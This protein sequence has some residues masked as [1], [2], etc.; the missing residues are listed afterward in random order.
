MTP[1]RHILFDTVLGRCGLV[2]GPGGVIA[3]S[4]PEESD[5]QT[6]ARLL[7]GR[8]EAEEAPCAPPT[9]ARIIDD[10][11]ALFEGAPR[12]LAYAGID[13]GAAPAFDRAVYD[14]TLAIK[15]GETRRYGDLARDLGDVGLSRR[16]GQALG[17][18]PVPI[19]VPCHRVVGANGLMTGFS[20]PGG[21]GT[22]RRLLRIEGALA[23]DL[24]DGLDG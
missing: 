14:L 8:G 15:P 5:A 17:R 21:T 20:A 1:I 16:V 18:N 23:P 22:K 6:R 10:I 19:I 3:A 2:W 12:D 9:I 24:F 11:R 7:R 13:L 4:F